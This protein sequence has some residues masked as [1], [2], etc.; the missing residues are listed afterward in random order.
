MARLATLAAVLLASSASAAAVPEPGLDY[1]QRGIAQ[2]RSGDYASALYLFNLARGAGSRNPN[3]RYDI[4]LTLYQ[5]GRDQEAT[6]AFENL[7]F[8]PGYAALADYHL[9]L[10]ALRAGNREAATDSLRRAASGEHL[11]LRQVAAAALAR[12]ENAHPQATR[13]AYGSLGTGYD[14]NAGYQSDALEAVAGTSDSFVEGIGALELPLDPGTFL[15]GG[16]YL[17][18]Y[19]EET[20]FSQQTGQLALRRQ[21]P[22]RGWLGSVTGSAEAAFLAGES[23]HNAG[24][25]ALEARRELGPGYLVLRG[26]STRIAAGDVFSELDGWRRAAGAEY[27]AYRAAVA[28]EIEFNDRADLTQDQDG[29]FGSRSP[30]RQQ[31]SVRTSRPVTSRLTLEWRARYRHSA[32]AD[33]DRIGGVEAR[34]RDELT[35]SALAGRW[36]LSKG[37][38]VLGEARYAQNRSSLDHYQYRRATG[39]LGIELSM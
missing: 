25:V 23:L 36:R 29:D 1:F 5:L 37:W 8:E 30:T 4:A 21:A 10:I 12:L 38:S 39:L 6:A 15:F 13:A 26:S 18:E 31:V 32:Y 34:R 9:G 33:P 17:R 2:Y 20:A 24:T 14:S 28:Y 19:S 3:L 7:Y 35:E 22:W 27:A 16:V 11:P